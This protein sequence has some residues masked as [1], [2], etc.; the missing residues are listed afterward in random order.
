MPQAE[1]LSTEGNVDAGCA[2]PVAQ[3]RGGEGDD[4]SDGQ[5]FIGRTPEAAA[6]QLA[7]VLA[8]ATEC[9]LATVQGLEM[10]KRCPAHELTRHRR[11]AETLVAQCRELGLPPTIR[12]LS[13]FPCPRLAELLAKDAGKVTT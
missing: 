11:I 7:V 9:Q 4:V 13:G 10:R 1:S 12:G 6:R 8:W 3:G 5:L 2:A